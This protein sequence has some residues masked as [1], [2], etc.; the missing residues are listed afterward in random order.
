LTGLSGYGSESN[1][2]ED[3]DRDN[4]IAQKTCD[5]EDDQ[6][7]NDEERL[8]PIKVKESQLN[9]LFDTKPDDAKSNVQFYRILVLLSFINCK[10]RSKS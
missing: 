7:I 5:S 9:M 6:Q 10:Y 2:S 8:N 4:R 1:D 3:D